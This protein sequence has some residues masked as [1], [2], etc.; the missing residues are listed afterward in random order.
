[1]AKATK[2][3]A[4]ARQ[5]HPIMW[6]VPRAIPRTQSSPGCKGCFPKGERI[7]FDCRQV[8]RAYERCNDKR[9]NCGPNGH[10]R[11]QFTTG[12]R[13]PT[14]YEKTHFANGSRRPTRDQPRL[15]QS[16]GRQ[17]R[18]RR[19]TWNSKSSKGPRTWKTRECLPLRGN[20]GRG[21][22]SITSWTSAY[23]PPILRGIASRLTAEVKRDVVY[24]VDHHL[25]KRAMWALSDPRSTGKA[26]RRHPS[27]WN[28][29]E[30][31]W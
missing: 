17:E 6:T 25:R 20:S 30:R 3:L 12:T 16:L 10:K 14:W 18:P 4:P 19:P 9:P 31:K 23:N 26:S 28:T 7:V 13:R 2:K 21:H 24:A 5:K 29:H 1:M 8:N 27:R 11:V 15:R 22:A